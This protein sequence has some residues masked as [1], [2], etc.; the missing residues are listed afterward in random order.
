MPSAS[1]PRRL[2][3][4]AHWVALSA[5]TSTQTTLA[6]SSARPPAMPPPMLGLVPVTTATLPASFTLPSAC[7][8]L[9]HAAAQ[10][11]KPRH[12]GAGQRDEHDDACHHH[13]LLEL[14][15][16]DQIELED[17]ERAVLAGGEQSDVADVARGAH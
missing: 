15:L 11:E 17:R 2:I 13:R 9:S 8:P 7:G 3:Q 6:P 1:P 16:G 14:A 10:S 12:Q 5:T 4:S